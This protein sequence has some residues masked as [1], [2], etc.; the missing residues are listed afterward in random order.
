MNPR[1]LC[2]G[3]TAAAVVLLL[4]LPMRSVAQGRSAAL[5]DA[6]VKSAAAK[7]T[8]RAA[9]GH[10]DLNGNWDAPDLP[11]SAHQDS[12]GNF[13]ID[14]PP[15][16]GGILPKLDASL[17][18]Q[19]QQAHK[20]GS[21]VPAFKPELLA[22]VKA[23]GLDE[24]ANDPI[25]HCKPVGVPRVGAPRQILQ[26]TSL[27]VFIYDN[28]GLT[29]AGAGGYRLVPIDGRPHRDDVDP[30]YFGDSVGHWEGD[31]L[32]V[33]VTHLNDETW[34]ANGGYF[35]SEAL[36]V[37]ERYTR[38]GDSLRWEATAEDPN[39]MTKPWVMNP[40]T[41]VR[42]DGLLYEEPICEEREAAHMVNKY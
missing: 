22:K 25:Y 1:S 8:P 9:D 33:D 35:H 26:T 5:R 11:V 40:Q 12:S 30:S 39:V 13:Y 38:Q 15:A 37:V 23:L 29:E 24:V 10:P 19:L 42:T 32:V 21:N 7:P 2:H 18:E 16:N 3:L 36:H 6:A 17:D 27:I 41:V 20:P 34:L 4:M 28:A 14:V 31:T